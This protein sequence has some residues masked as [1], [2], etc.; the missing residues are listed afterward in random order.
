MKIPSEEQADGW[1][2]LCC[3]T[4]NARASEKLDSPYSTQRDHNRDTLIG[5][6]V[7]NLKKGNQ[8]PSNAVSGHSRTSISESSF[9]FKLCLMCPCSS[10]CAFSPPAALVTVPEYHSFLCCLSLPT[11]FYQVCPGSGPFSPVLYS[12]W[13]ASDF[14]L[15]AL[16]N[17]RLVLNSQTVHLLPPGV[18]LHASPGACWP[19]CILYRCTPIQ[20]RA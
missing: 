1:Y 17:S 14:I 13:A 6:H 7:L 15:N 4:L 10:P 2:C 19:R 18:H 5:L 3:P 9:W 8:F 11:H 12:F 20:C 16:I